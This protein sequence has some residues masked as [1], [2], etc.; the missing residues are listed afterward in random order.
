MYEYDYD[1]IESI[2]RVLLKSK[3][4]VTEFSSFNSVL[5]IWFE[6]LGYPYW[7]WNSET[8]LFKKGD[9]HAIDPRKSV[10]LFKSMQF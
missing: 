1:Y 8:H 7:Y 3:V 4:D 5:S 6:L 10:V 9:Y 2:R